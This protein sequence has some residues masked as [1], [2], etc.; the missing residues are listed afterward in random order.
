MLYMIDCEGGEVWLYPKD[1][2]EVMIP[3]EKSRVI[4]FRHDQ[5]SFA[6]KPIGTS[7]ALQSWLIRDVQGFEVEEI[8]GGSQEVD[9]VYDSLLE[10][11]QA[12]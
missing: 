12:C 8:T 10:S 5:V 2:A 4:L 11:M 3:A 6:Y 1:G 9:K 7:L